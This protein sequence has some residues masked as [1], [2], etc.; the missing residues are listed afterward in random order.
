MLLWLSL[1]AGAAVLTAAI[2][3]LVQHG[4]QWSDGL[5]LGPLG[6]LIGAAA[7]VG[8]RMRVMCDHDGVHLRAFR[9]IFIPASE[10]KALV[11]RPVP[12]SRGLARAMVAVIRWDGSE[13]R[14]DPTAATYV[15]PER[16]DA[17]MRTLIQAMYEALGLVTPPPTS[18]R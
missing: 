11:V 2:V 17:R 3:L 1:A 7:C 14:L 18:A 9:A 4:P 8:C 16:L 6:V 5:V 10:V 13:V 12:G 15:S